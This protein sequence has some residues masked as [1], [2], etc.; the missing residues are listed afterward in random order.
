LKYRPLEELASVLRE[1]K[2]I[3]YAS[4][5]P[6][7]V[8]S[9]LLVSSLYD[10]FTFQ[11]DGHLTEMLFAEYVDLN[12]RFVPVI[13]RVSTAE[14]AIERVGAEQ[15]DLVITMPRVGEMDVFAFGAAVKSAHP[16]LPVVLLAYDT[17]ELALLREREE[18]AAAGWAS[19]DR[20]FVWQG[21]ARLFLAII[22]WAED[23]ANAVHDALM[24]GVKSI[25]LIEDS[26]RFYSAYLPL[27]YTE[28]VKQTQAL[29]A[30]GVNRMQKL[31]RMRARAKI[32]LAST[33][34]EG[35]AIF[36]KHREHVLG[37]IVDARFPRG[38]VTSG[39]AGVEFTRMVKASDPEIPVLMQSSEPDNAAVAAAVGADFIDKSSPTLLAEVRDFLQDSLGFGDFVFRD[40]AGG[41]IATA[42]DLR[43]LVQRLKTVPDVSLLYHA[44]RNDFSTWLMARTEFDLAK[45]LRPVRCEEFS[46]AQEL[47]QFLLEQL[48]HQREVARAGLVAEFSSDSFDTDQGF[49]R[50]GS[51]S[52]GGK[53][54]GLAFFHSLANTYDIE[55]HLPGTRIFIPPSAVLAT[56]IFDRFMEESRLLARVL[57]EAS[58]DEVRRHF[59][60]AR[61]PKPATEALRAFLAQVD[62]PLA[63][64]SSSLLED[65]S[66]QPFAGIYDTFMLPNSH[67]DLEVRLAELS[68]AIRLVYA[69]TYC[70]DSK[71][72]IESTPNRLEEEKMAVV[73]QQVV[74]RRHGNYLY[75]DV[76]GVARSYD[77][78][79]MADMRA[80]DGVASVALGLGRTVVEGGR[81]VRFSPHQPQRLYQF[82]SVHDYFE[83]SQPAFYAL[84]L[85]LM[86]TAELEAEAGA[87]RHLDAHLVQLD[88]ATALRHGTLNAVGSVYSPDNDRV[89]E[90]VHRTGTKLVTMAGV[91]SGSYYDLP[92]ALAFLLD[93]GKSGFSCHVEIE[94]ALNLRPSS[95]G[96]H[97][98]A[99]LQ[100]R[101]LV[102]GSA[103]R[104]MD[105]S[106]I[107]PARTVCVSGSALGHGRFESIRD[108]VYVRPDA[109]DRARTP[110]V[111]T[112]VGVFNGQLRAE[113]RPYLLIGPGRWGSAD[114][115]L[116]I[117]VTWAQI[118]G[119]RCIVE[120][121]MADIQV[122]PSQGS[123]FFQNITAFGLGYF[124]IRRDDPRSRLDQTWLDVQPARA[125]SRHVRHLRFETPLEVIVDGRSGTGVV[126]RPGERS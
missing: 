12:L 104:E 22:K 107:D 63:V 55:H 20:M 47:R 99:F 116:G 31:M 7:R 33:Y 91:L 118:S 76:A 101:P 10:S 94:F 122:A 16:D 40:P 52:L 36:S 114:P 109:F 50:I 98:L 124:T 87:E 49:T 15:F 23:R 64:R 13:R 86:Q 27:L 89:Y 48:T 35:E 117:P 1:Q 78:Y 93:V 17:R 2:H 75:P 58:D 81:C 42:K 74:G 21:D 37:V 54:R 115:W 72:Y 34:E 44:C 57:G 9:I 60:N 102:F 105:L 80:E 61:L 8:R 30:E 51:G 111:A 90:G 84:D 82:A 28:I 14:E 18:Q 125:E 120:T 92:R 6:W 100:I 32:L 85:A 95:E 3:P 41:V 68:R 29:M 19:I 119:A 62:Y 43:S 38:G 70:A 123:H 65:A 83:N 25:I 53:G 59:L 71:S 88:L 67:P 73:I 112:E 69:S 56:D 121:E 103:A 24:A 5:M 106:D 26:V 66:H 97:E 45:T 77:Y 79:P 4:L 39:S 46:S 11:E 96:P 126:V 110:A 113:D 108:I